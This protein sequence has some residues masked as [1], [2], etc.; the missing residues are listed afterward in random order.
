MGSG[1]AMKCFYCGGGFYDIEPD[2]YAFACHAGLY[3]NCSYMQELLGSSTV[4]AV[5]YLTL[6]V[7][8]YTRFPTPNP[9]NA[10]D[11]DNLDSKVIRYLKAEP[12]IHPKMSSEVIGTLIETFKTDNE[13]I[14][15]VEERID[16][17]ERLAA[18]E[19]VDCSEWTTETAGIKYTE[20]F[21]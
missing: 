12:N 4:R 10:V 20:A 16:T 3:P 9:D 19:Q 5:K 14:D 1:D 8:P 15:Q 21:W 18:S 11:Y 13:T 7:D 6:S 17:L 2:D